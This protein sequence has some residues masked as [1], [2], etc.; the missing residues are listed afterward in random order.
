MGNGEYDSM[1]TGG[2]ILLGVFVFYFIIGWVIHQFKRIS[3]LESRV[4]ELESERRFPSSD[5]DDLTY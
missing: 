4:E 3:D 5:L 2:L 1:L